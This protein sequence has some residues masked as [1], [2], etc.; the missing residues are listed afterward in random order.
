[1]LGLGKIGGVRGGVTV[2]SVPGRSAQVYDRYAAGL[3][4]QAL[5]T[6]GDEAVAEQVVCDVIAGECALAPAPGY[7]QDD[8]RYRLAE[9][10]FWR[11][12]ELAAAPARQDRRPGQRLAVNAVGPAEPGGLL[13]RTELGAL[14][15]VVFGGLGYV[16]AS[17]VLGI[18]PRDMA[19]LLRSA[20]L[21]LTTSSAALDGGE[22]AGPATC[23]P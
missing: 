12:Q 8:T 16:R 15:L 1:M 17:T 5:L 19:A 22:P 21:R 23:G 10:A 20:L 6:L 14:G 9:S 3:Y 4:R 18:S 11:C 13:N 7:G 2:S